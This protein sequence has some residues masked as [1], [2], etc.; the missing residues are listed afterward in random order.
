MLKK[1]TD[2]LKKDEKSTIGK[3]MIV[4]D[5]Q[6]NSAMQMLKK[7]ESWNDI[8]NATGAELDAIGEEI[9]Q[10]RGLAT[11]VQYRMLIRSKRLRAKADGTLNS[12]IDSMART[13][14]CKP[15]EFKISSAIESGG[16]EPNALIIEGLPLKVLSDAKITP[17]QVIKM[18]EQVASADVRVASANFKGT[19]RFSNTYDTPEYDGEFGFGKG[20]W[21]VYLIPNDEVDLPI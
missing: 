14:N 9:N 2:A 8:E 18:V 16:T 4:F 15:T 11:D 20:T 3:I 12:I 7:I 13:L 19:F 6:H 5:D 1:L 21:S 10:A 17:N